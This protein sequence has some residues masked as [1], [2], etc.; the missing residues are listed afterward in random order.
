MKKNILEKKIFKDKRGLIADIIYNT[1]INH[2]AYITTNKNCI[3]GN[4]YHKKTIQY[5]FVIEGRIKYYFKNKTAK[6]V[7]QLILTKGDLIK[8]KFNEIHA[9]K[10]LSKKSIML[11]LTAGVRGGKDYEKD[12]FRVNPI[13]SK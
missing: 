7:S 1:K 12:T 3:R 11:A 8:S 5:T 4:H 9:F 13:T 6:K 2:I 10:T